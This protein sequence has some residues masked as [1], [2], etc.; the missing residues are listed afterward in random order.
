MQRPSIVRYLNPWR[1]NREER[2]RRLA[3]LRRRDGDHCARCRRPIR[4]DLPAGHD[5]GAKIEPIVPSAAGGEIDNHRLCHRRCYA[6][7][8]DHTDEVT[9]RMRR[10]AEAELFAKSRGRKRKAA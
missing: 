1:F 4:F 8:L 3:E 9:E 6:P 5:H 10:K 7:G 2:A